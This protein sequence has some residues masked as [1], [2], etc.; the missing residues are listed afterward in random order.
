MRQLLLGS[1]FCVAA[2]L[3]PGPCMAD[4][5][6]NKAGHAQS[7]T[8]T[9]DKPSESVDGFEMAEGQRFPEWPARPVA[10][11]EVPPPPPLVPYM[12]SALNNG[13][14]EEPRFARPEKPVAPTAQPPIDAFSPDMPWPGDA[15]GKRWMPKDGYHFVSPA[16]AFDHRPHPDSG[17]RHHHRAPMRNNYRPPVPGPYPAYPS[18]PPV[19]AWQ[20]PAPGP[21]Y[22][23]RYT[24]R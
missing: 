15:P 4:E 13:M 20:G 5:G 8:A 16:F 9:A 7:A 11:Q 19:R 12:S 23:P 24:A 22:P 6:P 3:L 2:G 21:V 14:I 10:R 18:A 1:L 17:M